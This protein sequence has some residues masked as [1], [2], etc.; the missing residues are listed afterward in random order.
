MQFLVRNGLKI[1]KEDYYEHHSTEV[2]RLE[3]SRVGEC[4][5]HLTEYVLARKE[6]TPAHAAL[7]II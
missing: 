6:K 1:D 3:L 2:E 4:I 7:K 5:S